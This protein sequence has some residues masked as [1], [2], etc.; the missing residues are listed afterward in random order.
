MTMIKRKSTLASWAWR[1]KTILQKK[2]KLKLKM[3]SKKS[4]RKKL[5]RQI[6][7]EIDRK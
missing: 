6:R 5:Q 2:L 3:K 7:F 4:G 1:W